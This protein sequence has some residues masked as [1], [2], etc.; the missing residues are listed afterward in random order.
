ML[1]FGPQKYQNIGTFVF[2][3]VACHPKQLDSSDP[4]LCQELGELDE[5][6]SRS[7][8]KRTES[9][10]GFFFQNDLF[11][12]EIKQNLNKIRTYKKRENHNFEHFV[13]VCVLVMH[14][15][16]FKEH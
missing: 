7:S 1:I 16:K 13:S 10:Q 15:S 9:H 14:S 12:Q 11:G 6:G 4:E 3:G 8:A 2:S 5:S